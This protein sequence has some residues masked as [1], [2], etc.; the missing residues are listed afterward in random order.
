MRRKY[1]ALTVA[2]ALLA[3]FAVAG[4]LAYLNDTTEEVTNTFTF[5]D[6][7]DGIHLDLKETVFGDE[8]NEDGLNEG[9][10]TPNVAVNMV[11]GD[12]VAKN[13][14]IEAEGAECYLFVDVT[15]ANNVAKSGV[16]FYAYS[17][18]TGVPGYTWK[19]VAGTVDG[20]AGCTTDGK[21]SYVLSDAHGPVAVTDATAYSI[22]ADGIADDVIGDYDGIGVDTTPVK[23][24]VT[25]NTELTAEDLVAVEAGEVAIPSLSFVG[26][27][28]QSA[29]IA[30]NE[31]EALFISEF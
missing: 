4:T 18:D 14:T 27:A 30:A 31:V 8:Y 22:L 6:D 15:V 16:P 10:Q 2:C 5:C 24:S 11:P 23:G 21:A 28:I 12:I 9:E 20:T 25:I 17:L 29:N 1:L 3:T 26:Y 19:I 7:E 13:P